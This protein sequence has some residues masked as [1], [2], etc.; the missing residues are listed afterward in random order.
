MWASR[1][2]AAV[3]RRPGEGGDRRRRRL[4]GGRPGAGHLADQ[5]GQGGAAAVRRGRLDRPG[6]SD[7]AA[8]GPAAFGNLVVNW[9]FEQ[10]LSGWEVLGAADAAQ[11][12]Q[13]RTS[14]SCA[15][16][17]AGGP[18][19]GRVGLALPEVGPSAK[20]GQR[21]VASAWVR[22]TAPGQQVTVRLAGADG[23]EGSKTTATTLPGLEWRRIIVAHTVATAGPLRL[24]I[25]A[26]EVPAGDALLVDEV[27]VRL[28]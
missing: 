10:D 22:S 28:A 1:G 11:E 7:L 14:G 15:S 8:P 26:D 4:G 13:G 2:P 19:P 12:P 9:S 27:V 3:G 24:E 25:V 6:R 17:R 18:E 21:Y 16:V 23:K 20:R 5:L